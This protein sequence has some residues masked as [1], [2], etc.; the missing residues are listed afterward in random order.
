[1]DIFQVG[2]QRTGRLCKNHMNEYVQANCYVLLHVGICS[3]VIK[4]CISEY[5]RVG[6]CSVVLAHLSNKILF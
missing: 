2:Y 5:K 4:L 3:I 6:L 1:M